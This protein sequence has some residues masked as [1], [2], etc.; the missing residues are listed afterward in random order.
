MFNGIRTLALVGALGLISTWTGVV[1]PSAF[2]LGPE[3][4]P[5]LSRTAEVEGFA[6]RYNEVATPRADW[7]EDYA[8]TDWFRAFKGK[9]KIEHAISYR[10]VTLDPGEYDVWI[11]QGE[12]EWFYLRIGTRSDEEQPRIKAT[13]KLYDEDE[14]VEKLDLSLKLVS[15]G[16]KLK[17]SIRAGMYEG[18]GNL[19]VDRKG[20]DD[21]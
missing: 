20:P 18:H 12:K 10:R 9:L 17:F 13:F 15:K 8:A 21:E 19:R 7:D 2:A 14:G 1:S 3:K 16:K 4:K 5:E 6:A 11:E